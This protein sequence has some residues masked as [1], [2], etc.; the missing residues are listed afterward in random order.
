MSLKQ[1]DI[2]RPI[3][4]STLAMRITVIIE[5]AISKTVQGRLARLNVISDRTRRF[6]AIKREISRVSVCQFVDRI[7][8]GDTV[9]LHGSQLCLFSDPGIPGGELFYQTFLFYLY[10]FF[11]FHSLFFHFILTNLM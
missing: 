6:G 1:P 4:G 2:C 9:D 3:R 5:V 10:L 11:V 7:L 8:G